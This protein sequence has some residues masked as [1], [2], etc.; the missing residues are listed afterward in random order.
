MQ[1]SKPAVSRPQC[2]NLWQCGCQYFH[3]IETTQIHLRQVRRTALVGAADVTVT[4]LGCIESIDSL[5]TTRR[6]LSTSTTTLDVDW[7]AKIGVTNRVNGRH[8]ERVY[9]QI[10]LAVRAAR[11]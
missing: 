3:K 6:R 4:L 7:N 11:R 2:A 9:F 1:V 5:G 8:R 10:A